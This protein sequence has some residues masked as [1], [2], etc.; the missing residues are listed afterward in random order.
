LRSLTKC[1]DDYIINIFSKNDYI[2]NVH[3]I[4]L[5]YYDSKKF[6]FTVTSIT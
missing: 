1:E 3:N 5:N 4:V 2:I 6:W